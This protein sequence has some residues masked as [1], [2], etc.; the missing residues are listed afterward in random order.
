MIRQIHCFRSLV[1][2]LDGSDG[3]HVA[4]YNFLSPVRKRTRVRRRS[5]SH[6][7]FEG[8]PPANNL[9]MSQWDP[10]LKGLSTT[11]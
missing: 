7:H 11:Q 8:T 10:D 6:Y 9:K 3:E 2:V 4:Q 1:G 5:G